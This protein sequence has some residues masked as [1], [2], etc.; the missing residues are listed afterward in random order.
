MVVVVAVVSPAAGPVGFFADPL[1]LPEGVPGVLDQR[2]GVI[3]MF[4]GIAGLL[5]A[6]AALPAQLHPPSLPAV[7]RSAGPPLNRA[8]PI[9]CTWPHGSYR[10][11]VS[12]EP[13]T[14][15]PG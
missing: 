10:H 11:P 12:G 1:H 14:A 9:P 4:V 13:G 8:D 15:F 2:A 7:R 5:V 6:G 3:G